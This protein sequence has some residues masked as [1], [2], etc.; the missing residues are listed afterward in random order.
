[1][2]KY[3]VIVVDI[4]TKEDYEELKNLIGKLIPAKRVRYFKREDEVLVFCKTSLRKAMDATDL[5]MHITDY[6]VQLRIL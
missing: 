3:F 5:L 1:M 2:K 6:D 4:T